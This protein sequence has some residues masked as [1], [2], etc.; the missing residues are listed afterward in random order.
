MRDFFLITKLRHNIDLVI[1]KSWSEAE[2]FDAL[3]AI[4][5]GMPIR[6]A[7]RE[8]GIPESTLRTRLNGAQSHRDASSHLRVLSD[9]Q[10]DELVQFIINQSVLGLALTRFEVRAMAARLA[11]S[12]LDARPL[13]RSWFSSFILRHPML[14]SRKSQRVEAIRLRASSKENIEPWLALLQLD[15]VRAIK[16]ANRWNADEGGI[17]EARSGATLAVGYGEGSPLV[18][19]DY[20]SRA[21]TSFMECINALGRYL[22]PLVIFKGLTVQQQ[23]F[24]NALEDHNGWQ[25]TASKKGWMEER[26]AIEWLRRVF[27]PQ[28]VPDDPRDWRLLVI[29]GHHTHTT[30]DFMWECFSNQVYILFLPAH[31]THFLQPLDVAIFAPLKKAFRRY[32]GQLRVYDSSTVQAKKRFLY[33]YHRAR[34]DALT[35]ANIRSGWRSTGLW[36]VSKTATMANRFLLENRKKEGKPTKKKDRVQYV[37]QFSTPQSFSLPSEVMWATPTK[38]QELRQMVAIFECRGHFSPTTRLFLRKICKSWDKKDTQLTLS[39]RRNEELEARIE[40]S[41][42]VTRKKVQTDPNEIFADIE[43]I[44]KAKIEVGEISEDSDDSDES[45]TPTDEGSCIVVDG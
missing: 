45:E 32:L 43:A 34:I 35:E 10:E 33:C 27:L 29:D 3:T 4:A 41:R 24:P 23:W 40:A 38:S 28:T 22:D 15:I 11:S 13:G 42:K 6:A 2:M 26:I 8:W 44:R 19:K 9:D 5:D 21:W 14:K 17:M 1:M 7:A 36:P 16:P 31:C 30:V 25:F 20:N 39:S 18:Q 37:N 12:S